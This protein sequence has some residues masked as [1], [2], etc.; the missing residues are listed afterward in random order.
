[1]IDSVIMYPVCYTYYLEPLRDKFKAM[2]DDD[3]V[4]F[5]TLHQEILT[6]IEPAKNT[7]AKKG[8]I[9][10]LDSECFTKRDLCQMVE[11]S[12]N[13]GMKTPMIHFA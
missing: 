7:R 9:A 4:S 6:A 1:M 8:F 12:C 10:R 2:K 11:N 3:C 5:K 13:S